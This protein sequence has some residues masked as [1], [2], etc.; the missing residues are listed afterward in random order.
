[1]IMPSLNQADGS[2]YHSNIAL[3][4]EG[5][6]ARFAAASELAVANW[7]L[8]G[9]DQLPGFSAER[10]RTALAAIEQ[11]LGP[12][13]GPEAFAAPGQP[14]VAY[15]SERAVREELLFQ[16]KQA[17]SGTRID[18]GMFYFS[19]C[20]VIG[21]LKDAIERGAR[22]RL[23]LDANR[24]AF[25][26][27]KN[28]I[29]NRIVAA[30]FMALAEQS[31]VEVSWAAT[32]GEQFHSKVLRMAGPQQ[33]IIFLGSANWTRR[34]LGNLNLEANPLLKNTPQ[35]SKRFDAYGNTVWSNSGGFEESLPYE[36][37]AETGWTSAGKPGCTASG[38]SGA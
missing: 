28:G 11:A 37:R 30:E 34:N 26:R 19:D 23:L 22:L 2:A 18:I 24:D 20:E 8:D 3:F 35:V 6:V 15:R 7:S 5:P 29:P 38:G 25:G 16:F 9:L 27:E 33:D 1:M 12:A 14:A 17:V 10:V 36:A 21:P 31:A 32:H 13:P 4:V